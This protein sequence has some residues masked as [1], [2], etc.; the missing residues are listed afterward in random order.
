MANPLNSDP[1]YGDDYFSQ[2]DRQTLRDQDLLAPQEPKEE[3]GVLGMIGDVALAPLAG[4]ASAAEGL[5]ELSNLLPGV[6]RDLEFNQG[7]LADRET[8]LGGFLQ[9]TTQFL[10]GFIP[11]GGVLSRLGTAGRARKL[12]KATK[13]R[14]AERGITESAKLKAGQILDR[15]ARMSGN[16]GLRK[17]NLYGK[18]MA[19]GALADF[20]VFSE[21]EQRLSNMLQEIPGLDENLLLE[22]LAQ[23][24]E[25]TALQSRLKAVLEG[26]GLGLAVEG[27]VNVLK[28]IGRRSKILQKAQGESEAR[29]LLEKNEAYIEE[30]AEETLIGNPRLDA[31]ELVEPE[32]PELQPFDEPVPDRPEPK[33]TVEKLNRK[34]Q[35]YEDGL[36]REYGSVDAAPKGKRG[37]LTGLQNKAKRRAASE[38]L[39]LD[40]PTIFGEGSHRQKRVRESAASAVSYGSV[41]VPRA[42]LI[43]DAADEA[44]ASGEDLLDVRHT[45]I[46]GVMNLAMLGSEANEKLLISYLNDF[47]ISNAV[48]EFGKPLPKEQIGKGAT[49]SRPRGRGA[50]V[51]FLE[52]HANEASGVFLER[53]LGRSPQE[54]TAALENLAV[55]ERQVSL[56]YSAAGKYIDAYLTDLDFLRQAAKGRD[57]LMPSGE[58][59]TNAKFLESQNLKTT[60]AAALAYAQARED[61][62]GLLRAFGGMRRER[63][64]GF[65]SMRQ[66]SAA[67]ASPEFI[68]A[69]LKALGG[70]ERILNDAD[71]ME[72][73]RQELGTSAAVQ[74]MLRFDKKSRI[75]AMTN[76]V[77][78]NN[79]LSAPRTLTTNLFGNLATAVYGPLE[80]YVGARVAA[81]IG[82]L[83]GR[84][85][86]ALAGEIKRSSDE[87]MQLA[88]HFGT[89]WAYGK[90]AWKK[91]DYILDADHG[92][93][94]LP[95]SMQKAVGAENF[96]Y[97][98][99]KQL[100]PTKGLGYAVERF[101][102]IIR[103]PSR[104]LMTTDEFFKQ[105]TYRSS[106]A[107][108]L[109]FEGRIKL[110]AGEID[111]IDLFVERELRAMTRRGQAFTDRNLHIEASKRFRPD[112]ERYRQ[113][114]YPLDALQADRDAWVKDQRT[115]GAGSDR[116][117]LAARALQKARERTFTEDLD[118]ENGFL[119]GVGVML[120]RL[121]SEHPWFRL[122]VPFIRTPM[123]ILIY[124]SK[125]SAVPV[126]NKDLHGAASY[127]FKTRLGSKRLDQVKNKMAM[128]LASSDPQVQ[129][130][131]LGRMMSAMG[132][133]SLALGVAASGRLTGAGPKDHRQREILRQTGWQPYSLKIGD[134]YLSYQKMDP[135]ATM[136]A[137]WADMIDVA[138][139]AP[140]EEQDDVGKM[141]IGAVASLANNLNSKSYLQGLVQASGILTDPERSV[142]KS[143][144]RLAS[145]FFV[146]ALVASTRDVVDPELREVRGVL[147]QIQSRIPFLSKSLD[148][149]RTIMGEAVDKRTF[150]GIKRR[151]TDSANIFLPLMVNS[152]TDDV[153]S[154]EFA[155]L[156]YP[157]SN[158]SRFKFS[159]DLSEHK[160]KAGQSAYDRWLELTG[161]V[162]IGYGTRRSLKSAVRRLI[163]S[164]HYQSLPVEGVSEL[165][166]DSPRVERINQ[167][168]TRY[169][170]VA[171]RQMLR[172]FP[173][174]ERLSR[175]QRLAK[176]GLRRNQDPEFVRNQLFPME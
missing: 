128:Q 80:S 51:S 149:Q 9:G 101:G 135:F 146:P 89:A 99:N 20:L 151:V 170:A 44:L 138:R 104:A 45:K 156:A 86:S 27:L 75:Y 48:D 127:M 112:D 31:D 82:K 47:E 117:E 124:A 115:K 164:K 111:D 61:F 64:R 176:I 63:G 39:S 93:L 21:D 103:T 73:M 26:A 109:M 160:N 166:V 69:R 59:M 12:A 171:L 147:D 34:A 56:M 37:Y 7:I 153:V 58:R 132:F 130:A 91:K 136:L 133:S 134:E 11:V 144:G 23:D 65:Y 169:R 25:D 154:K 143:T 150:R 24:D 140:R 38:G 106:I 167:L 1:L 175:A 19:Q 120:Q 62:S 108:D 5:G 90:K 114:V 152:S 36:V 88:E 33:S 55:R 68:E 105:W 100:D 145:A 159:V 102:E 72:L 121:G 81:G 40:Q 141:M 174:I 162:K 22:F 85:V 172:E 122:F 165:D 142:S 173:E 14:R 10:A 15:A 57:I 148:P 161:T 28:G 13:L 107:S 83:R 2:F 6:E 16:T 98:I 29:E 30:V 123:N 70:R 49:P 139:Y 3:M 129:A 84:D 131:A 158:P 18:A 46:P 168:I 79:I 87:L 163:N 32:A 137:V 41:D 35:D 67:I 155:E 74:K 92:T 126:L 119:S 76:E 96:G 53:A 97:V 50:E 94:D 110:E 118:S 4:L 66:K 42:R 95:E 116:G 157:F 54:I 8:I 17:R 77:F 113:A 60:D 125:R 43:V 71:A 52:A 78:V